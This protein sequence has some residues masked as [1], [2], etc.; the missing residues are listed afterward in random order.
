MVC[1]V[2]TKLHTLT[3]THIHL[4][5]KHTN[6][7]NLFNPILSGHF[8]RS[9]PPRSTVFLLQLEKLQRQFRKGLIK[10]GKRYFE[11]KDRNQNVMLIFLRYMILTL[12]GRG[13]RATLGLERVKDNQSCDK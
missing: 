2:M 6:Q 11:I 7:T 5:Y 1:I 4:L 3:N 8:S 9:P 12:G 10:N 13:F